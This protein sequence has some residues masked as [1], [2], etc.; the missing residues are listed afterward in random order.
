MVSYHL[1]GGNMHELVDVPMLR[2][3]R[4]ALER[5]TVPSA[6]PVCFEFGAMQSRP[7]PDES[8]R[9]VGQ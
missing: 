2:E 5:L 1:G 6:L 3:R 8:Q 4:N 9:A 7:L